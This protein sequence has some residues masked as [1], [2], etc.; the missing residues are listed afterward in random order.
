M[1]LT[2]S[3]V[4]GK[5]D[6]QKAREREPLRVRI[7]LI[8][9]ATVDLSLTRSQIKVLKCRVAASKDHR[10]LTDNQSRQLELTYLK[11]G[12]GESRDELPVEKVRSISLDQVVEV[13]SYSNR[14]PDSFHEWELP[15]SHDL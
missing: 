1:R 8:T 13:A 5:S 14:M 2:I 9:G 4:F 10:A 15:D 3:D 12:Q 11:P 6:E 7:T